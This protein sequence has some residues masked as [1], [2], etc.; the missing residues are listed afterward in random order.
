MRLI[1]FP[2]KHHKLNADDSDFDGVTYR[3]SD[4]SS[5]ND[6]FQ[7]FNENSY[8]LD[9]SLT[10]DSSA[11]ETAQNKSTVVFAQ[12]KEPVVEAKR[13]HNW[14]LNLRI[15]KC[16]RKTSRK[17]DSRDVK[18][19]SQPCKEINE[20]FES[21]NSIDRLDQYIA[22]ELTADNVMSLGRRNNEE[23]VPRVE[24]WGRRVSSLEACFLKEPSKEK[25]NAAAMNLET[26]LLPVMSRDLSHN[27]KTSTRSTL[28]ESLGDSFDELLDL[29][30]TDNPEK[31][32][33]STK[34]IA[35]P[36]V[37]YGLDEAAAKPIVCGNTSFNDAHWSDVISTSDAYN[38]AASDDDETS[39]WASPHEPHN[40]W[41]RDSRSLSSICDDDYTAD[42]HFLSDCNP[43]QPCID[44]SDKIRILFTEFLTSI[45]SFL[46]CMGTERTCRRYKR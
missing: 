31:I 35:V 20:N 23:T 9:D 45:G 12:C 40:A 6:S 30:T 25:S 8:T 1:Y 29:S 10:C 7:S 38:A 46:N 44:V 42:G 15:A 36:N 11:I 22:E 14:L 5:S 13:P 34:Q 16:F 3:P 19:N 26:V 24:T 28:F 27:K 43:S 18:R 39:T 37:M 32:P 21:S 2:R 41:S 33:S 17:P 4:D